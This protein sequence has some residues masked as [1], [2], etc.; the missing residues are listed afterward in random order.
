MFDCGLFARQ[1]V[2]YRFGKMYRFFGILGDQSGQRCCCDPNAA[3]IL[4]QLR[5]ALLGDAVQS[6]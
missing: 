2:G 4:K 5:Q 1:L 6:L 3:G